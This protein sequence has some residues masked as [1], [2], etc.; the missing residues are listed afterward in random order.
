[1]QNKQLTNKVDVLH[2]RLTALDAAHQNL[3]CYLLT[4]NYGVLLFPIVLT[5]RG[6][7]NTPTSG[8]KFLQ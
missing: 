1:M 4:N 8:K 2:V 5:L 3:P 7:T 6:G